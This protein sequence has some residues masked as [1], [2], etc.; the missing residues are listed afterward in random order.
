MKENI[1]QYLPPNTKIKVDKKEVR[2]LFYGKRVSE[3]SK[4]LNIS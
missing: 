4:V 3:W 1:M 2:E